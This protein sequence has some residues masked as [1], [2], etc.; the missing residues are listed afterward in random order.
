MIALAL[1]LPAYGVPS[2]RAFF[3]LDSTKVLSIVPD[4]VAGT[5]TINLKNGKSKTFNFK[6]S[7]LSTFEALAK[8]SFISQN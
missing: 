6:W 4:P 5:M 8:S 7:Q 3:I 2:G 1:T